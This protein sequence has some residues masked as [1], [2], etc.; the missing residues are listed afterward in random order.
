MGFMKQETN[1]GHFIVCATT[2]S[3]LLPTDYFDSCGKL[4]KGESHAAKFCEL[5]QALKFVEDHN[6]EL[7][8]RHHIGL[9]LKF[10]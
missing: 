8:G 3:D 5:E 10:S 2:R 9:L 4:V 1:Q 6:I 7:G